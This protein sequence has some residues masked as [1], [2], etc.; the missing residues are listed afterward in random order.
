MIYVDLSNTT[1]AIILL[2]EIT[3]YKRKKNFHPQ[4]TPHTGSTSPIKFD[5]YLMK[6]VPSI[7]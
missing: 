7:S 1:S 5:S 6:F 2:D 4:T 3:K